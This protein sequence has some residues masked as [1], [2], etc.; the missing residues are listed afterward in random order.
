MRTRGRFVLEGQPGASAQ[1][2]YDRRHRCQQHARRRLGAAHRRE[3]QSTSSWR[4]D[5]RGEHRTRRQAAGPP[6]CHAAARP[7]DPPATVGRTSPSSRSVR[8]APPDRHHER[9]MRDPRQA[10][11]RL[12]D[13]R[14]EPVLIAGRDH[15]TKLSGRL[16]RSATGPSRPR[17]MQPLP[18][19][20]IS[21]AHFFF[22]DP[23]HQPPGSPTALSAR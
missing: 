13:D 18:A 22:C 9:H 10:L 23:A 6:R 11:R 4:Q 5:A 1:S 3:P 2:E 20:S 19:T 15:Q 14:R 12:F 7:R 21:A 8:A 17:L 16:Q